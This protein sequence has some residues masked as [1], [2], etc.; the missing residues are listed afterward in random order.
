[1]PATSPHL[2]EKVA[3]VQSGPALRSLGPEA[4]AEQNS[5]LALTSDPLGSG[6]RGA[7]FLG[8]LRLRTL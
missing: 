5:D 3:S 6:F 7:P 8:V 1:M 4:G 2:A